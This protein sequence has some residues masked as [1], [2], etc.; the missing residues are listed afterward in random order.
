MIKDY[1]KDGGGKY[2]EYYTPH[3]VAKI[4][5]AILVGND[6]PSNVKIYDPSAGS[7]TLLMNLASQIG[8]ESGQSDWYRPYQRLQSGYFSE[9]LQS[10]ASQLDSQW[11][12]AFHSQY[13]TGKYHSQQSSCGE[14]GLYRVQSSF[15]IRFSEWRD[16][17]ESLPNSSERFFAG[18]PKI[19][20]KKK[21]VW[22]FTNSLSSILSIV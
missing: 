8:D 4:I 16:Q 7:G 13:R 17:V 15:Q 9:I 3:S 20:N 10:L 14:D 21:R 1:N 6:Q 19:P 5:A 18:V 22:L 12:A 2:A 11:L